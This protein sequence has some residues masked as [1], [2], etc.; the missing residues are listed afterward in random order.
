MIASA[1]A[2][3]NAAVIVIANASA[4]IIRRGDCDTCRTPVFMAEL[5]SIGDAAVG[6]G[7]NAKTHMFVVQSLLSSGIR[8]GSPSLAPPPAVV[9]F[10]QRRQV[11]DQLID[12]GRPRIWR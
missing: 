7:I 4:T 12:P 5:L 6:R 11:G 3:A 1:D 2:V 10:G 9:I 8:D